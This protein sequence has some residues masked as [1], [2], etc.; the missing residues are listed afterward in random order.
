[1]A[2]DWVTTERLSL[3]KLRAEHPAWAWSAQRGASGF[4]YEYVGVKGDRRVMLRCYSHLLNRYDGDEGH[5]GVWHVEEAGAPDS[6]Y[7]HWALL[8]TRIE[9]GAQDDQ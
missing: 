7:W 1:M 4:S 6:R 5:T 9:S 3:R 8:D 2:S